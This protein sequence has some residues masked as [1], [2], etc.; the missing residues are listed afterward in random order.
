MKIS[1]EKIKL[2]D[3]STAFD[4]V[5]QQGDNEIRLGAANE[6]H[7]RKLQTILIGEINTRTTEL[8]HD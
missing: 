2:S 8:A 7:A 5:L 3:K 1:I 4:V 6:V